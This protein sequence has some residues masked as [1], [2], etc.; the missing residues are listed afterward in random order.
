MTRTEMEDAI[1]NRDRRLVSV[2][3]ILPTLATKDDLREAFVTARRHADVRLED[4]RD[5][6]RKV[7]EGVAALT[8]VVQ[9]MGARFEAVDRR[10]DSID[11]RFD[12]MDHRFDAKDQRFDAMD[13]RFDA[14]D[15]RFGAMDQRFDAMDQRL[16]R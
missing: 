5:D 13:Q 11:L 14:M 15:Q 8:T 16:G 12:V 10:F 1:T 9:S 7:A 3:Q 2:E 6:I 4:V